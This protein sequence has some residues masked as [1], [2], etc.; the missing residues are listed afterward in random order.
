MRWI[1]YAAAIVGMAASWAVNAQGVLS[2]DFTTNA[3]FYQRDT[4][5]GTNTTQYLHELSS[6]EGWLFLRYQTEQGFSGAVR[7]DFYH[8]SPLIDPQKAFTAGGVGFYQLRQHIGPLEITA[9]HFYDQI[10]TGSIFRAFE[11]R[12]IGQDYAMHGIRVAYT[13]P[14]GRFTAKAF[15]GRQRRFAEGQAITSYRLP[16]QVIQGAYAEYQAGGTGWSWVPGIGLTKR[17]LDKATMAQL[18]QAINALPYSE[19][20]IPRYNVFAAAAYQTLQWKKW[21]FYTE[22]AYK[23]PDVSYPVFRDSMFLSD[24]YSLYQT[25]AYSTDGFGVTVQARKIHQMEIRTSPFDQ[26]LDGLLVY[27]PPLAKEHSYRLVARYAISSVLSGE[28]GVQAEISFSP[29]AND[30]VLVNADYV[31]LPD[32]TPLYQE[33]YLHHKR[34]WSRR[35]KSIVGIQYRRY[36]QQVYEVKPGVPMVETWVP[37]M[38]WN[39]R[40]DTRR[41]L[42]V[43]L[44]YLRSDQDY[45][46]FA[47]GLIEFNHRKWGLSVGASDMYNLRPLRTAQKVHYYS[48]Y[49]FY[50]KGQLRTGLEYAR[51][52]GGVVCSGGVCRVEPS[53][54]GLKFTLATNF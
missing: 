18:V 44:Q 22:G 25:A 45:G 50:R 6:A 8:N 26:L 39:L 49:A 48:L 15:S 9:G 38:D 17:T 47:Y 20:F 52:I 41:S 40:F 27:Q 1:S 23:T 54:R 13:S 53:F 30:Y 12:L 5:I 32:H 10:G 34:K 3:A 46:D 24:G 2:G 37:F 43:E 11:E 36:N 4:V 21:T 33:V 51:Q 7:F 14:N 31:R 29:T 28:E 19:R 35:L 16:P 42:K